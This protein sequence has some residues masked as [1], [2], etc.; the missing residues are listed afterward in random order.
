M[1][2]GLSHCF[3]LKKY[4]VK[5]QTWCQHYNQSKFTTFANSSLQ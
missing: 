5:N 1:K 4:E 3:V 2:E